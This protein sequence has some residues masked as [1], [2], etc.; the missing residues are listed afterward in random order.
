[1][2]EQRPQKD[3]VRGLCVKQ[4][5]EAA[6][7]DPN[8]TEPWYL[9]L[10]GAEGRDIQMLIDID[11]I[12]LTEVGSIVDADQG[13]VVAVELNN[14]AIL[15]LR[16]LFPGLKIREVPFQNLVKGVGQFSWP[17]GDEVAPRGSLRGCLGIST[18]PFKALPCGTTYVWRCSP[19]A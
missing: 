6:E 17:S 16:R 5:R 13:K 7:G 8:P 14:E 15:S 11:L 4:V 1:M 9:T 2:E 19:T 18:W 10:A 12:D 3:V